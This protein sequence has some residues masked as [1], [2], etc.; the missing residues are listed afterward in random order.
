MFVNA[1]SL[2]IEGLDSRINF[3]GDFSYHGGDV[4]RTVDCIINGGDCPSLYQSA[5]YGNF[6]YKFDG[7][8]PG[9][10][11]VD[12][13]FAEFVNING[14]KGMRMF[15]VYMQEEKVLSE[16]DIYSL[17]GANKPLQLVDARIPVAENGVMTFK[18]P[19]LFVEFA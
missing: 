19:Q 14:P 7:L 10:Y 17:V 6:C 18:E 3:K 4:L 13:H 15:D 11:F 1:G 5:R 9:D 16:L 8:A 12:L 2:A